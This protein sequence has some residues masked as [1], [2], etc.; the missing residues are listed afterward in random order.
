MREGPAIL[1][2]KDLLIHGR[3]TTWSTRKEPPGA[4]EKD[5]LVH[6]REAIKMGI[7]R[8]YF[9][10]LVSITDAAK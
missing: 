7:F 2:G 8:V 3:R 6:E 1:Q 10:Y 9:R 5:L 4:Q